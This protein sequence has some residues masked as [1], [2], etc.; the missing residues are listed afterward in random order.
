MSSVSCSSTIISAWNFSKKVLVLFWTQNRSFRQE[1]ELAKAE[2]SFS[3][4]MMRDLWSKRWRKVKSLLCS[5]F[6]LVTLS[7]TAEIRIPSLRKFSG[8]SLSRKKDLTHSMSCWWNTLA[9]YKM[10]K[11]KSSSMISREAH[12]IGI[13]KENWLER[14]WEKILIGLETRSRT[15]N[16]SACPKSTKTLWVNWGEMLPF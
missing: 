8:Y 7:T 3:W 16:Y 9:D 15:N 1:K 13:P 12:M 2:A 5:K 10:K 11:R 6:Y 4:V 14:Q